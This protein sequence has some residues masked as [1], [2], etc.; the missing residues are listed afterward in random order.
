MNL[1][2]K[3]RQCHTLASKS[4]LKSI[5]Q[6]DILHCVQS[7]D[8]DHATS[9]YTYNDFVIWWSKSLPCPTHTSILQIDPH[10]VT[11]SLPTHRHPS[12]FQFAFFSLLTLTHLG[13]LSRLIA[14]N[15]MKALGFLS[16][17][18][19]YSRHWIMCCIL[20]IYNLYMQIMIRC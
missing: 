8:A 13:R 7:Q 14:S 11:F 18:P 10:I 5:L 12:L 20:Y 3:L 17:K 2:R 9:D 19:N 4:M 6:R 16:P 1:S 15:P